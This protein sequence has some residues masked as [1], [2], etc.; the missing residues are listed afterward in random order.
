MGCQTNLLDKIKGCWSLTRRSNPLIRTELRANS[1]ISLGDNFHT[2]DAMLY[3][4]I[5]GSWC[6]RKESST[7]DEAWERD[8]YSYLREMELE[9]IICWD[10]NQQSPLEELGEWISMDVEEEQVVWQGAHSHSNLCQVIQILQCRHLP[11]KSYSHTNRET[12]DVLVLPF[13]VAAHGKY[14]QPAW[15]KAPD[16]AS[17]LPPHSVDGTQTC[18]C[19]FPC[20]R[21][22]LS[23][24]RFADRWA[25]LF[26]CVCGWGQP[27]WHTCSRD[28]RSKAGSLHPSSHRVVGWTDETSD[29]RACSRHQRCRTQQSSTH[30][31][32][33]ISLFTVTHGEPY[34]LQKHV[35]SWVRLWIYWDLEQWQEQILDH[36]LEVLHI[37]VFSIDITET[38][39]CQQW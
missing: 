37:A 17:S 5:S 33:R 34:L 32:K 11:R 18:S 1:H 22:P 24:L 38:E 25:R 19:L 4:S 26:T 16:G 3:S 2:C 36:F 31:P 15:T 12:C 21:K 6:T 23:E 8:C 13:W 14:S 9:R 35:Q 30:I 29:A 7:G 27:C 20:Q 39:N 10:W 28:S